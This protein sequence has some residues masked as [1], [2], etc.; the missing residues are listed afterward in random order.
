MLPTL[1]DDLSLRGVTED[2]VLSYLHSTGANDD[3]PIGNIVDPET[4]ADKAREVIEQTL[5]YEFGPIVHVSLGHKE[6]NKVITLELQ[7]DKHIL[8]NCD[9]VIFPKKWRIGVET[10]LGDCTCNIIVGTEYIGFMHAGRPELFGDL[11]P[12][13]YESWIEVEKLADSAVVM[14]PG[15]CGEHYELA[16]LSAVAGTRRANYGIKTIWETPGYDVW[17][18][19]I[20]EFRG[21][22]FP[23]VFEFPAEFHCPFCARIHGHDEWASDQYCRVKKLDPKHPYSPRDCAFL[24]RKG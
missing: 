14:G 11:I 4:P 13:F 18:A 5:D 6:H 8:L 21:F 10:M 15:I 24:H 2:W 7:P 16:D 17:R 1:R 12:R 19:I 9:A 3:F 23:H 20:G 22:G